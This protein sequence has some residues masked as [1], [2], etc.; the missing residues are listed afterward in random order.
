VGKWILV[1]FLLLLAIFSGFIVFLA[2]GV[3]DPH[4]TVI[5]WVKSFSWAEPY[6]NT[7]SIG[8]DAQAW[9]RQEQGA[10]DEKWMEITALRQ[11]IEQREQEQ[12]TRESRLN[13]REQAIERE[14]NELDARKREQFS[15][16]RLSQIYTEMDPVE[17]ARI[18]QGLERNIIIDVLLEMDIG[19]SA[20]ILTIFPTELAA[21]LSRSIKEATSR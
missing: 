10:I 6:A 11:E 7:Y 19:L 3:L 1:F 2:T 17:A 14:Q 20:E 12:N 5:P 21:E 8:R 9:R 18:L 16:E 13:S 4:E 15:V